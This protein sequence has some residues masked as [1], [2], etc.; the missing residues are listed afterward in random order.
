MMEN[1]AQIPENKLDTVCIIQLGIIEPLEF[2]SLT[3]PIN[4]AIA[5]VNAIIKI[6][7]IAPTSKMNITPCNNPNNNDWIRF[8]MLKLNLLAIL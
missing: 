7:F 1:A 2:F 6:A 5:P 4:H 3:Y 8:A